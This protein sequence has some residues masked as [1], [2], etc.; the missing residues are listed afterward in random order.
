M[1]NLWKCWFV[2]ISVAAYGFRLIGR[3]FSFRLP[4]FIEADEKLAGLDSRILLIVKFYYS[5]LGVPDVSM[6]FL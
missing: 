1:L 4:L 2:I 6:T 3:P 5:I